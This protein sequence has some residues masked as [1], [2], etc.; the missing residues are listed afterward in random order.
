MDKQQINT[1]IHTFIRKYKRK[2]IIV[3]NLKDIILEKYIFKIAKKR[4]VSIIIV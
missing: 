1:Y 3:L 4:E 2:G